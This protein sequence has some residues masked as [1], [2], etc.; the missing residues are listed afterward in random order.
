MPNWTIQRLRSGSNDV[1]R[2]LQKNTLSPS[3]LHGWD[4]ESS[5]VFEKSVFKKH[6]FDDL[7][8]ALL[9]ALCTVTSPAAERTR[10]SLAAANA[11]CYARYVWEPSHR[12]MALCSGVAL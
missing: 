2:V 12:Y 7:Q 11:E 10:A 3:Q 4:W 9:G 5:E 6:S 8:K 1:S